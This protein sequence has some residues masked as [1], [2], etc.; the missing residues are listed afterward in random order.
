MYCD[1]LKEFS[2]LIFHRFWQKITSIFSIFLQYFLTD[3]QVQVQTNNKLL[4]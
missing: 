4:S 3:Q 1:N 2:V